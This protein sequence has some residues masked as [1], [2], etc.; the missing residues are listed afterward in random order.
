MS[1][2]AVVEALI[3]Q[4][5][6][7]DCSVIPVLDDAVLETPGYLLIVRPSWT[8]HGHVHPETREIGRYAYVSTRKPIASIRIMGRAWRGVE[9]PYDRTFVVGDM[10]EHHSFNLS[11]HGRIKSIS[12]S[13]VVVATPN[14]GHTKT[15]RLTLDTFTSR[16]WDL[17]LNAAAARNL[18]TSMCL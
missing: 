16:N 13:S 2:A 4:L 8:L 10:V 1:R 5:L 9:G 15:R 11:Y 18:E 3:A 12:A 17:D 14:H 7:G 6:A